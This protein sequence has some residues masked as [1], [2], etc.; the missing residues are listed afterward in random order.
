M[1]SYGGYGPDR[2]AIED[3][4]RSG[5]YF[6]PD[7]SPNPLGPGSNI[8]E[9]E[10]SSDTFGSI[11]RVLEAINKATAYKTQSSTGSSGTKQATTSGPS[12]QKIDDN[13]SVI[14]RQPKQKITGGSS[15]GGPFGGI[16]GAAGAIGT[17][18][19]VFGPLGPV[20]GGLVGKGIDT[21]IG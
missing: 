4:M 7:N 21:A 12:I 18:L 15:G 3:A 1:A 19:G 5:T 11:G 16:G 9:R 2:S 17:A 20:V 13:L 10:D 14:F 6:A 8:D